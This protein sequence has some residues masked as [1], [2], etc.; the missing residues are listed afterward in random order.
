MFRS[1]LN[2]S[3]WSSRGS[4]FATR[5]PKWPSTC[6]TYIHRVQCSRLIKEAE[7]EKWTLEATI[8]SNYETGDVAQR[9]CNYR[10]VGSK[11]HCSWQAQRVDLWHDIWRAYKHRFSDQE[12]RE[13]VFN[14]QTQLKLQANPSWKSNLTSNLFPNFK[15]LTVVPIAGL[16]QIAIDW[17]RSF[18]YND[19]WSWQI[20]GSSRWLKCIVYLW[21][22]ITPIRS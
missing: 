1:S 11:F 21:Y 17:E 2:F 7:V 15:R 5:S 13:S 20:F 19:F 18:Y 4:T 3:I 14:I 8:E 10:F 16:S 6:P 22:A 9:R 12:P